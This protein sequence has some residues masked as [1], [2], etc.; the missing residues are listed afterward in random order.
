MIKRTITSKCAKASTIFTAALAVTVLATTF[1][2]ARPSTRSFT[3][4]GVRDYIYDR[5]SVVMNTKNSSVYRRFVANRSYCPPDQAR[6]TF[7]VPT[8]T[9]RCNL[10]ICRSVS[11]FGRD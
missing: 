2:E 6:V 10:S 8:R 3:C 7:A 5:G 9:G 1:A 11:T 4:E